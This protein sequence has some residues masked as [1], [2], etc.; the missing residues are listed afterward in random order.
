VRGTDSSLAPLSASVRGTFT[1]PL[2]H[3]S[4]WLPTIARLAGIAS[5]RTASPLDGFDCWDAI[6][7]NAPSPRHSVVHNVPRRHPPA[8][9]RGH[10]NPFQVG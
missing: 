7:N 10:T 5:P 3:A 1:V 2:L 6:A 9:G 4:D 8:D